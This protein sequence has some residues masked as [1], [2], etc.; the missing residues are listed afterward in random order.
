MS[1]Q[2]IYSSG[3]ASTVPTM[4]LRPQS[5]TNPANNSTVNTLSAAAAAANSQNSQQLSGDGSSILGSSPSNTYYMPLQTKF[6]VHVV[7]QGQKTPNFDLDVTYP[8]KTIVI[9]IMEF[10]NLSGDPADFV[11]KFGDTEE[12]LTDDV[13]FLFLI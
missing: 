8:I 3:G 1:Q 4:K 7:H 11:L 5:V 13:G 10:L 9:Q 12:Q 2:S 6:K